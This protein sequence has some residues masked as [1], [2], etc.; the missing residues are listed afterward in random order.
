M[1]ISLRHQ[2]EAV[3]VTVME[4]RNAAERYASLP[5][6]KGGID[7]AAMKLKRMRIEALEAAHQT[8]KH[9]ADPADARRA[10]DQGSTA[11]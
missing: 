6:G 2:A 8:L 4:H 3:E 7:E 11:E 9:L 5:I 10:A 1:T